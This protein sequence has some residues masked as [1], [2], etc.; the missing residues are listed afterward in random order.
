MN[1]TLC[2]QGKNWHITVLVQL[3]ASVLCPKKV[4]IL[5]N[6]P[7]IHKSIKHKKTLSK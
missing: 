2:V 5:T 1:K 7:N 3:I 4:F 6:L